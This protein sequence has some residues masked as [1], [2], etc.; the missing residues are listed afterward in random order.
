MKIL[1]KACVFCLLIALTATT[2][3]LPR[4]AAERSEKALLSK[5]TYW[6]YSGRAGVELDSAKVA[7][8]FYNSDTSAVFYYSNE[9]DSQ[10]VQG[11]KLRESTE[12]LFDEVFRYDSSVCGYMKKTLSDSEPYYFQKKVLTEFN[13]RSVILDI[14]EV[15]TNSGSTDILLSFE[16][17]TKTL[18]SFSYAAKRDTESDDA[19]FSLKCLEQAVADYYANQLKLSAER[20]FHQSDSGKDYSIFESGIN[21]RQTDYF[22]QVEKYIHN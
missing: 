11:P 21:K 2:V 22:E 7:E 8:L 14:I 1:K 6:N 5:K 17:K 19:S 4:A 16:E 15:Q 10:S 20:Y 18:I 9:Y 12:A 13:G 3:L